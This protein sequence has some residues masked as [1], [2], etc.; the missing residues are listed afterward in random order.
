MAISLISHQEYQHFSVIEKR[1]G[2]HLERE[3]IKGFE[4]DAKAPEIPLSTKPRKKKK[5]VSKKV[6][7]TALDKK[8]VSSEK[9]KQKNMDSAKEKSPADTKSE[10]LYKKANTKADAKPVTKP[11]PKKKAPIKASTPKPPISKAK[12]A[13]PKTRTEKPSGSSLYKRV[14]PKSKGG[15]KQ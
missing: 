8:L 3:Q 4:A 13:R 7:K 9:Q 5:K 11:L 15:D 2:I 10:S 12:Q 6:K 1:V 14:L